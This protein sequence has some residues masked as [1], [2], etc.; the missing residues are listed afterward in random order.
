MAMYRVFRRIG[1]FIAPL[2]ESP[3]FKDE[4]SARQWAEAWLKAN[5][6]R[7]GAETVDICRL[8]IS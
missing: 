2:I 8:K 5:P 4:M 7:I 3:T 1:C 6:N